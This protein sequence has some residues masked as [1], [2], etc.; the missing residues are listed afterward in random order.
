M[1]AKRDNTL[2]NRADLLWAFSMVE[3]NNITMAKLLGFEAI[4]LAD[5]EVKQ[6]PINNSPLD[7]NVVF[8]EVVT[9]ANKVEVQSTL[10]P[11]STAI[12]SAYYRV[13]SRQREKTQTDTDHPTLD[14]PPDW[15]SQASPTILQETT[16]RIPK[17]HQVKPLHTPLIQWARLLPLLQRLLG[18]RI[19]GMQVDIPTL[20]RQ[21]ADKA[22]I[23]QIP[24]KQRH[25]WA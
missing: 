23:R 8:E 19:Q 17:I 20:V 13:V 21:V 3:N 22:F 6:I 4:E 16:S 11:Q 15:F 2:F 18:Q 1:N 9:T 7:F 5:E 24:H 12:A 25:G 10:P 14:L